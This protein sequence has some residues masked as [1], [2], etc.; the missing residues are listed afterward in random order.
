MSRFTDDEG[1]P[2]QRK[3]I[4]VLTIL[5]V[6]MVVCALTVVWPAT[7]ITCARV[8]PN[9]IDCVRQVKA[10]GLLPVGEKLYRNVQRAE[11]IG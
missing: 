9:Q 11:P 10:L 4:A 1:S 3:R 6:G 8:E 2:A 7:T 5:L